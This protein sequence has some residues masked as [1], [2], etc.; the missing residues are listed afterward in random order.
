V[1]RQGDVGDR[2]YIVEAGA[3]SVDVDGRPISTAAEGGFFGEIALLQDVP[4]TASVRATGDGA[5]WAL[6]RD[7]FLATVTG[8]PQADRAAH[9]VSAERLRA[10]SED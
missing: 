8:L 4:R 10:Q 2:F 9:A 1:I 6:G 3:F 5:V 7:E